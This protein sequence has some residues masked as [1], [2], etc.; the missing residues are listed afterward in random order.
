MRRLWLPVLF[1]VVTGFRLTLYVVAPANAGIDA[2]V[3]TAAA[4]AWL[5]GGDP[6]TTSVDGVVFAAPPTSL[7]PFIPFVALDPRVTAFLWM[8]GCLLVATSAIRA[9]NL[10]LWWVAFPPIAD[11]I[12]VASLDVIVLG[13][14]VVWHGRL[15]AVAPLL[16]IYALIPMIGERRWRQVLLA[17]G[18][19][20]ASLLVLPWGE[21]V[22]RLPEISANLAGTAGTTSVYGSPYLMAVGLVALACLGLR[23]AG[24]LAV[25]VL[26]PST[27]PHYMA[28]SVPG[29]V[30]FI[31]AA[32]CFPHPFVTLGSVVI[33][34]IYAQ[35]ERLAR[36]PGSIHG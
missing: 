26:W 6:W 3:Y 29:L 27:Q 15:G 33:Y 28:V 2:R 35:R 4:A 14:L 21:W 12:M 7:V 24:W 20:G 10:P 34:A 30:P 16:K 13:S 36:A 31:A 19:V 22:A 1:A 9:L 25:P 5:A 32:W 8:L 11:G 17:A 23:R 18:L